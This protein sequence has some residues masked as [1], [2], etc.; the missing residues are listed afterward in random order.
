[1]SPV[2]IELSLSFGLLNVL[3]A[4]L[5][6]GNRFVLPFRERRYAAT[7]EHARSDLLPWISGEASSARPPRNAVE[8][9]ALVELLS[10]YG[11]SL[12]GEGRR[13]VI[14]LANELHLTTTL[15]SQTT[16][17]LS[18]R[19]AAAAFRLGDLGE[20]QARPESVRGAR[21]RNCRAPTIGVRP[22]TP[23]PRL[24]IA[25][26]SC[27]PGDTSAVQAPNSGRR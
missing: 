23:G 14:E 26:Q 11:R 15:L 10:T 24:G 9:R 6:V 5:V 2:L 21:R 19:R 20:D 13:R 1:M 18:W 7:I 4:F 12:T 25:P 3:I 8:R 16:N 27:G 17:V 22:A